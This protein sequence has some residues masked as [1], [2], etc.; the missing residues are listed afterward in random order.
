MM[1]GAAALFVPRHFFGPVRNLVGLAA[2]VPQKGVTGAVEAIENGVGKLNS[3]SVPGEEHEKAQQV[4]LGL[5]NVNAS[6][7]QRIAQLEARLGSYDTLRKY[8][9]KDGML[10]PASVLAI[11]ADGAREALLLDKGKLSNLKNNDWVTSRIVILAGRDDG[12]AD[13]SAVLARECLIGWIEDASQVNAR[14]VLLSDPVVR[15]GISAL[16]QRNGKVLTEGGREVSFP[17]EG[18]GGGKMR[19]LD[20]FHDYVEKKQIAVGDY[21]MSQTPQLPVPMVIGRIVKFE[22]VR[23]KP[24]YVTALVEPPFNAR[25]LE[26]VFVVNVQQTTPGIR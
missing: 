16:V 9:F 25:Q 15:R 26:Q 7:Y 24:V 4:I 1:V 10:I 14:V 11:D 8:G 6:L 20:I 23:Q 2:Y 3:K 21:V 22:Q 5:N 12:I 13:Q 17:L 19:L 18:A